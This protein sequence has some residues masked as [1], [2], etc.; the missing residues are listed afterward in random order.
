MID[1]PGC[2]GGGGD[3]ENGAGEDAEKAVH[4]WR[5]CMRFCAGRASGDS[6]EESR[7]SGGGALSFRAAWRSR[8]IAGWCEHAAGREKSGGRNALPTA[9]FSR[10]TVRLFAVGRCVAKS[11][12]SGRNEV[13]IPV[14]NGLPRRVGHPAH[15]RVWRGSL[16]PS[17]RFLC[18]LF[19]QFCLWNRERTAGEQVAAGVAGRVARSFA[20]F[21]AFYKNLSSVLRLGR[22]LCWLKAFCKS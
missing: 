10:S 3:E 9:S 6:D 19:V 17:L 21:A 22:V 1:E 7:R 14:A 20:I 13:A 18:F 16:W 11:A 8:E 5:H 2:G 4:R 15:S 12:G